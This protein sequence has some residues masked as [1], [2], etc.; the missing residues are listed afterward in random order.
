MHETIS[1]AHRT[2]ER[3]RL[4]AAARLGTLAVGV[5]L[6]AGSAALLPTGQALAATSPG[7]TT[8]NVAVDSGIA[9]TSLTPAFT[10]TGIPGDTPADTGA[11]TMDVFSN[12]ATGYNVTVEAAAAD[13]V[14]AIA[15][16]ADVIP[17]TDLS[18]EET[19]AGPY[20]PLSSTAATTVYTQD[21]PSAAT[22][23]DALSN[24][25]EFN[26]GIPDVT[27]DTYSVTLDYVATDN[28]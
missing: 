20:L 16:N 17:V 15:G 8:A 25:Y 6:A 26:T 2:R 22:P 10:L 4:P 28:P 12:N 23:G 5:A 9:I 7:T 24:D 11:V 1:H 14:G 27:P 21:T 3:R 19:G 13:L 18:V